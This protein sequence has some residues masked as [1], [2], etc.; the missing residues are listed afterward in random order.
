MGFDKAEMEASREHWRRVFGKPAPT[1]AERLPT[2]DERIAAW[3]ARHDPEQ[4]VAPVTEAVLQTRAQLHV[5]GSAFGIGS[6]RYAADGS[7]WRRVA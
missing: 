5:A 7:R 4:R 6:E 3:A 1:T 2:R